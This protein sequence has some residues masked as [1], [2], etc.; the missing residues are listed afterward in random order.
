MPTSSDRL[1]GLG[2]TLG[3]KL[4]CRVPESWARGAFMFAADIAWRRQGP[5]VQVLEANLRRVTGPQATGK[6]LRALSREGMRSYARYWL[7][8][9]RLPVI[10]RE[11]IDALQR[12]PVRR[13][14]TERRTGQH[15]CCTGEEPRRCSACPRGSARG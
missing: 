6:Q 15:H 11:R 14:A 4:I 13:D 8:V 5:R 2:Y 10:S 1:I 7:E 12:P 3:W 9:F